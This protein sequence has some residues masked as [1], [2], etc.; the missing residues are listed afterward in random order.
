MTGAGSAV[1]KS[2]TLLRKM[3]EEGQKTMNEEQVAWAARET[4][5]TGTTQSLKEEIEGL[6]EDQDS[7]EAEISSA[8]GKMSELTELIK[9]EQGKVAA[10]TKRKAFIKVEREKTHKAFLTQQKDLS[11]SVSALDR[12]IMVIAQ[13]QQ[14]HGKV[15]QTAF[16]QASSD[17]PENIRSL[18][19][20]MLESAESES[21]VNPKAAAYR[22]SSGGVLD[23]LEK[24]L[25]KF[26]KELHDT[27][28]GE[29]NS[30]QNW[31]LET[32]TLV[33]SVRTSEA[34]IEA[35]QEAHG[36]QG[37]KK[38]AAQEK[39]ATVVADLKNT[40]KEYST[41]STMCNSE[42]KS[43]EEKQ[44]L[45]KDEISALNQAIEILTSRVTDKLAMAQQ[46]FLQIRDPAAQDRANAAKVSMF[47][48]KQSDKLKSKA[49]SLLAEKIAEDPFVKVRDMIEGMIEK[50]QKEAGE[51]QKLHIF[52]TNNMDKVKRKL[53]KYNTQA[54]KHSAAFSEHSAKAAQAM[55]SHKKL[56]AEVKELRNALEQATAER[57]EAAKSFAAELAEAQDVEAAL[58]EAIT[59]LKDFY[60]KASYATAFLQVPNL[61]P[62]SAAWNRLGD[63]DAPEQQAY[64][65]TSSGNVEDAGHT[66]GEATFGDAYS[67]KQ[68]SAGAI[69]A[70]L[71]SALSTASMEI[72]KLKE[73]E[74]LDKA[75]FDKYA[76]E[77]AVA[78]AEKSTR[79]ANE[80]SYSLEQ[81]TKATAAKEAL[82]V[83]EEQLRAAQTEWD[84]LLPQCP[85]NVGGTKDVIT[86]EERMAQ[87]QAE[88]DSL[89]QCIEI[90]AA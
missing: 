49:L 70:I 71:E 52:C 1:E 89:K 66:A 67:G 27:E 65:D 12:A 39:L 21:Q 77:T 17:L 64:G 78:V 80:K 60:S 2:V 61:T 81:K 44:G 29:L 83:A 9:E 56:S 6:M 7:L 34:A 43:Y 79:A 5:C 31:E 37:E 32:Q 85:R 57:N 10:A 36:E 76:Q 42:K 15:E 40:K 38:A 20:G 3:V 33:D 59:V 69:I 48:S 68:D 18:A 72:M 11:E 19:L 54:D 62:G 82:G 73:A 47:L 22:A 58:G 86:H 75:N 14:K 50:L 90:L 88:I 63:P 51:E 45:R 55:D 8:D 25:D 26:K 13:H 4:W 35:H 46:S 74:A 28:M 23:M 53:K 30:R 16:L 24:L 87:R 84:A 41:T